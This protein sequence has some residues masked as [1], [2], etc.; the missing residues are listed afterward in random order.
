MATITKLPSGKYRAQVRRQGVYR[1]QTFTRKLDAQGWAVE[2]ERAVES[3]SSRG[4][5]RPAAGMTLVDVVDAYTS[6]VRLARAA[7]LSLQQI[8]RVI[9][10]VGVRQL[11]AL[12]LQD[13]IRDR[14]E[15]G[16]Q[17][18]SILRPLGRLSTLLQWTRDIKSIDV[19]PDIVL[20]AR[21][22]LVRHNPNHNHQRDRVPTSDEIQRLRSY[23]DGEY[24]GAL[25]MAAIMD[26]AM[27][28]AMR[29][30]EICRITF[31][32]VNWAQQ[33]VTIR[34]RKDPKQKIGNNQIVPLLPA[35][36]RIVSAMKEVSGGRGRIFPHRSEYVSQT[37]YHATR[38][39]QIEG[40]TFHDLRHA[41]ITEL[42]R[43]GL[44]IPEVALVSGHRSWRELKRYTQLTAS[45]V[46]D[47]F[48]AR[49]QAGG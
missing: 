37:W 5:M 33:T 38:R 31:N 39:L 25:P 40:L 24:G 20:E 19:N 9:G 47:K 35:A 27:A 7:V 13:W 42:F 2:T 17:T 15:A 16:L 48:R 26:F 29:V 10:H 8:G 14:Q 32:D 12:H 43:K 3:G 46:L 4:V 34:D 41:A 22:R 45:D 21:R 11:N 36:M 23:F 6:Q 28:S 1:A 18:A 44:G 49:E 30:G